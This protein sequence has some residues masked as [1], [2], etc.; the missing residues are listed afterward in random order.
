MAGD[1]AFERTG[2]A[3]LPGGWAYN[4]VAIDCHDNGADFTEEVTLASVTGDYY[5]LV[6]ALNPDHEGSYGRAMSGAELPAG[7]SP[8]RPLQDFDCP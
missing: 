3:G 7:G 1:F 4:H 8:C 2:S 6:V 5:Y